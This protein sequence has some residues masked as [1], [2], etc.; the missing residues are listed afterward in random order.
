[1]EQCHCGK[2]L[3]Q[4]DKTEVEI[5]WQ[6]RMDGYCLDCALNRCD[7]YPDECPNRGVYKIGGEHVQRQKQ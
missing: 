4:Y 5:G 1:M 7:C 2:V 6:N 3:T